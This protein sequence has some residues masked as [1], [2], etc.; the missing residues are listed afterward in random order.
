TPGSRILSRRA[1]RWSEPIRRTRRSSETSAALDLEPLL[2]G[3]GAQPLTPRVQAGLKVAVVDEGLADGVGE[4][5]LGV[6]LE[7]RVLPALRDLLRRL[8]V[9]L[10]RLLP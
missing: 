4:D 1:A 3:V 9:D 10:V 5:G 8:D 7:G 6:V 2:L